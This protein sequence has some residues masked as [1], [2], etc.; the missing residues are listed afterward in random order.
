[1]IKAL[2]EFTELQGISLTPDPITKG[3]NDVGQNI[4][5]KMPNEIKIKLQS[6]HW[7]SLNNEFVTF[8]AILN[9]IIHKHM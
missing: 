9:R 3:K 2:I 4:Y 8:E 7:L 6:A 5:K 1:M